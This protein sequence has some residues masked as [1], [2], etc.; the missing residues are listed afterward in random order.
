MVDVTQPAAAPEPAREPGA[1]ALVSALSG[2]VD[3]SLVIV[4]LRI[5]SSGV[6]L[7]ALGSGPELPLRIVCALVRT[8]TVESIW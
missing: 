6:R 8:E 7:R 2:D 4:P 3:V 5:P 1:L